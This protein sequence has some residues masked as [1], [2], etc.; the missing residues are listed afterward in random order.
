[1]SRETTSVSRWIGR[2]GSA[3]VGLAGR[4]DVGEERVELLVGV[5]QVGAHVVGRGEWPYALLAGEFTP[6]QR[7]AVEQLVHVMVTPA[8]E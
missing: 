2:S 5:P 4:P 3:R 6:A 8:D 7:A 1:M